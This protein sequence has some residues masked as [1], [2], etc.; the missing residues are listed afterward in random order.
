MVIT[1]RVPLL[2]LLG[3][4][5][6]VRRAR[7]P[8]T[9]WLWLLVVAVLVVGRPAAAPRSPASLT[10]ARAPIGAVR[11]GYPAESALLV[12]QHRHAAG[13]AAL[14]RDAWQPSAGAD[15]QPAP[16]RPR[17]PATGSVLTHPAAA[18]GGAATC[19]RSA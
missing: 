8:G 10:F 5:P 4:V 15:R 13:C 1:G 14:V 11:L 6:V 12:A 17:R 9:V 19:R 18:R 16:G 2:L 3:L 7:A